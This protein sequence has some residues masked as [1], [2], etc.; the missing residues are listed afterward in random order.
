ML[1]T[2]KDQYA[3]R[4]IFELAKRNS[5]GPVKI[6]EI[7][8]A[9]EIPIR[10]LEVI[11]SQLKKSGYVVSK[12]GYYGGYKLTVA[13]DEITVGDVLRF[14]QKSRDMHHC[15]PCISKN[16]CP[17]DRRCA[18]LPL[19]NRVQKAISDVY[20]NTTFQQLIENE[21]KVKFV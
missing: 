10:F 3:L 8:K 5:Q 15:V 21:K 13:S 9:Q 16:N 20:D 4:A 1:I 12:R 2:Q 7:A 6:S 17:F 18:F 11:M 14:M 19:W